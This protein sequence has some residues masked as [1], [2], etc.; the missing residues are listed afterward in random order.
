VVAGGRGGLAWAGTRGLLG[1]PIGVCFAVDNLPDK[2]GEVVVVEGD[3]PPGA[4]HTVSV[5]GG[6]L[7]VAQPSDRPVSEGAQ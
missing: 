2:I 3:G 7:L 6:E 1:R 5:Q 4:S